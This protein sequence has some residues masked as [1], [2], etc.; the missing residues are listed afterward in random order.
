[1]PLPPRW[2]TAPSPRRNR[3]CVEDFRPAASPCWL[4]VVPGQTS[5]RRR[6]LSNFSRRRAVNRGESQR[7]ASAGAVGGNEDPWR[8]RVQVRRLRVGG[9]QLVQSHQRNPGENERSAERLN[10]VKSLTEQQP[11]KSDCEQDFGQ[12]DER[13]DFRAE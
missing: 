11:C 7:P 9:A 10:K 2:T 12:P 13:R 8:C 5:L 4:S 1:M 6:L 3:S